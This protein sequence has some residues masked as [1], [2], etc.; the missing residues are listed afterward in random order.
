MGSKVQKAI[1]TDV[2]EKTYELEV[3]KGQNYGDGMV[4]LR[5]I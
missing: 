5:N 3:V 1:L 2:E 4:K